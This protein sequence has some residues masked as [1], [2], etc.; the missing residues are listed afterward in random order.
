MTGLLALLILV[1]S[2]SAQTK[3][4]D[5]VFAAM[6]NRM[7]R[8]S[9]YWWDDGDF[10]RCVQLLRFMFRLFPKEYEIA[11]DLGWMLENIE[12]N[13]EALVTYKAFRQENPGNAEAA[14]P[15]ANFYFMKKQYDKVWPII[16]PTLKGNPHPNSYRICAHSYERTDKL[17]ES[18]AVWEA[19]LNRFPDDGPAK[20]NLNRVNAKL[21]GDKSPN[22]KRG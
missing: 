9:D 3:R 20:V 11:T 12:R 8:Q 21:A 5:T 16:A 17:K 6:E 22:L 13:D 18:K 4:L 2:S 10:P 15:E 14:F 19:L 7:Y 1:T